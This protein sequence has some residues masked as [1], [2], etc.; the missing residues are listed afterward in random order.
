MTSYSWISTEMLLEK[1]K[2]KQITQN[3]LVGHHLSA[4]H[5]FVICLFCNLLWSSPL[6][7]TFDAPPKLRRHRMTSPEWCK[8]VRKLQHSLNSISCHF[9]VWQRDNIDSPS[10]PTQL[11]NN[12][13]HLNAV[14]ITHIKRLE[15]AV[16]FPNNYCM[17]LHTLR[18]MQAIYAFQWQRVL[19]KSL[20]KRFVKLYH[21]SQYISMLHA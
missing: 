6:S 11:Q 2:Y 18:H 17:M 4:D 20:Q 19:W 15:N 5:T 13:F 14:Q 21:T 16:F 9:R 10:T 8:N 3:W 12:I 7:Y 1:K